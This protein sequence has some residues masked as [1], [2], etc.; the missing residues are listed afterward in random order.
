[1]FVLYANLSTST[2]AEHPLPTFQLVRACETSLTCPLVA[3]DLVCLHAAHAS[4][5]NQLTVGN[6]NILSHSALCK[7]AYL[8]DDRVLPIT[9]RLL[10][11]IWVE[12]VM[13]PDTCAA[14]VTMHG[15]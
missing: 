5:S 14:V 8:H 6:I 4:S 11:D 7:T 3:M 12:L 2:I 13:P 10:A 1:M 9:E 15:G